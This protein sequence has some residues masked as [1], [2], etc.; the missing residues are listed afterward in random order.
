MKKIIILCAMVLSIY[1]VV[2]QNRISGKVT[3]QQNVPL[4]GATVSL[5]ELNKG[6]M[7][8]EK[9]EYELTNLPSGKNKVQFSFVGYASD[10]KTVLL[11]NAQVELNAT[12]KEAVIEAEEI[13]VS[14]G[15]HS[16]QHENAVKIDV[17][18][19]NPKEIAAT[20]NF[21]EVL[22]SVPGVDMISKGSGISKPVIRGLS[23]N[24]ILVLNNSVRYENYQYS[25][26][27][28]LGI[29]E[30]G[31][32]DVEVIKGPASLLYGSDAIG[33]VIN[34]IKEKPASQHT[35]AGDYNLQLF[36]NT[37]GVTNNLGIKG[38]SDKFFGGIRAGQK[39]NADF[40]QGGGDYA[41]N[42]R[43][44]E[45]SVKANAG[46]TSKAGLFQVFYDYGQQKLGLAEE[47]AIEAISERGRT[48]ELFYQQ[49]NTHLFSSRNKLYLGKTKLDVNAAYQNTTLAHFGEP[50][51]YELEMALAT[52]T[53]EAKVYLPSDEKSE[54]IVGVQG[55]NQQNT[56]INNRET[57]LLPNAAT[58]NYSAFGLLQHTFFD[59]LKLQAGARYDYRTLVSEEAGEAT[60]TGYRPAVEKN[61]GSF[62]GSAGA[63]FH[64]SDELLVRANFASAFRSPNLAELTSNG[65]HEA[66]Y[67]VGDGSLVPEKSFEGDFGLHYHNDNLTV[68]LA[69]FYN[70]VA[71]YIYISP[72]G[73]DTPEGLPIYQY[74]QNNSALYGGEAGIHLHPKVVEWLHLEGTFSSVTGIQH[75]GN[76]LP[77]IPAN[78]INMEVRAEKE[79]LLFLDQAF[80]SVRSTTAF[81]QN[82]TA[83]DETATPGYMLVDVAIGGSI[84]VKK[85]SISIIVSANNLFDTKYT[86]HLSTLK[87]VGLLNP[88]R[89]IALTLKVPFGSRGQFNSGK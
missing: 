85:Q 78:K 22:T 40:L 77:F 33:G 67:E 47:E 54:Y 28:P 6:T 83:P 37:L 8:N 34:F 16:T 2:A 55:M 12:L 39:S 58:N 42:T 18:K 5:P 86:D 69:G 70:R 56:N 29:D 1:T 20:P 74:M 30:F 60:T 71:N 25:S 50:G 4:P 45:Y 44:N 79:K 38:A 66:I 14:G 87:E 59:K 84:K 24:D 62:S 3:D 51:E 9:G 7:T 82:N 64:F 49:L 46:F 19:L 57:L 80:A 32:D 31:I 15:Y 13:V 68:D 61:F 35:I 27:H 23:M 52:T 63:T 21:T 17:L 26:H 10:I 53:Y 76:F 43:F 75:N 36:S 11:N 41:A 89:N 88:G 65:P 72:T 81:D 73:N 48:C